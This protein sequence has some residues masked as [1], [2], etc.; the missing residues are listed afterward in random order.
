M[1]ITLCIVKMFLDSVEF[2][3]LLNKFVTE[4]YLVTDTIYNNLNICSW[5]QRKWLR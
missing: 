2:F 1:V 3:A 5:R 4:D